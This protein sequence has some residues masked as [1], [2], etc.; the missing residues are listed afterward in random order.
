MYF[1][2][3]KAV[4]DLGLPQSPIRDALARAAEWFQANGYVRR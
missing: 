4:R 2:S 1:D 3:G